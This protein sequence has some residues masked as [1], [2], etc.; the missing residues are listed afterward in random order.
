[1]AENM[2]M[3]QRSLAENFEARRDR[4]FAPDLPLATLGFVFLVLL[5]RI[6]G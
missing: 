1:M 2:S 5:A 6:I 3:P 4:S